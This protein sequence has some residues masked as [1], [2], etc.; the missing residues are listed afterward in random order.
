L[1][2]EKNRPLKIHDVIQKRVRTI[3]AF[4]ESPDAFIFIYERDVFVSLKSGKIAI[5]S[6]EGSLINE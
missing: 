5:W 2:K 6:I 1:L 4:I 3:D